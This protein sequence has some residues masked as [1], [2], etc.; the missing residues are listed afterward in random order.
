MLLYDK[1]ELYSNKFDKIIYGQLLIP[2]RSTT[3]STGY[4]SNHIYA[5]TLS[6][7]FTYYSVLVIPIY[8]ASFLNSFAVYR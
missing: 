6:G 8:L 3:K 4:F 5:I 1:L 7:T 2:S